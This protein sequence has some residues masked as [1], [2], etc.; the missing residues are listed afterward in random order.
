VKKE[1]LLTPLYWRIILLVLTGA[2]AAMYVAFA[3]HAYS[4]GDSDRATYLLTRGSILTL[5]II[6][7]PYAIAVAARKRSGTF[8]KWVLLSLLLG[9]VI[10]G[11][12]YLWFAA[13]HAHFAQ[14]AAALRKP[15]ADQPESN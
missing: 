10:M 8:W 15:E 7:W 13:K 11:M 6:W 3:F 12:V 5:L 1:W 4:E 2:A 9:P 14:K